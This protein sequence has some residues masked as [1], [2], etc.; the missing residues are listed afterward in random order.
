MTQAATKIV[1]TKTLSSNDGYFDRV[2]ILISRSFSLAQ[3]PFPIPHL[4]TGD[5]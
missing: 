2:V 5:T 1:L 4:P 3:D